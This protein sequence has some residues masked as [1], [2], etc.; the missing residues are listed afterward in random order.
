MMIVICELSS[1]PWQD[2]LALRQSH[3]R[4]VPL[5]ISGVSLAC[6]GLSNTDVTARHRIS[7][8]PG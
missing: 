1:Q 6:Q 4:L 2:A 7:V 8:A 5:G 3:G